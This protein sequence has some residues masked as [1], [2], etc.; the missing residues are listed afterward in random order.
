MLAHEVHHEKVHHEKIINPS[1]STLGKRK[2]S[3]GENTHF[4]RLCVQAYSEPV[5]SPF[6][7][8]YAYSQDS[9]SRAPIDEK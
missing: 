8:V 6:K 7:S 1:I 5:Q 4:Y 3:V 2:N 9:R